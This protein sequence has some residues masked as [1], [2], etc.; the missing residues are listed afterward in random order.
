MV[1]CPTAGGFGWG[2]H[3]SEL[4]VWLILVSSFFAVLLRAMT[5]YMQE[6]RMYNPEYL[7]R[8]YLVVLNK[9]DKPEVSGSYHLCCVVS[10]LLNNFLSTAKMLYLNMHLGQGS[11][12]F[13]I[14][15]RYCSG[16]DRQ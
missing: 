6:L 8:P 16:F 4:V 11:L 10:F 7:V 9:I 2:L 1:N 14:Y 3:L 13:V 5:I 12:K 15:E